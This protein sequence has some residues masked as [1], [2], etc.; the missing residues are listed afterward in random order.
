[1]QIHGQRCLVDDVEQCEKSIS[2][3]HGPF[4]R[5]VGGGVDCRDD[6]DGGEEWAV[7]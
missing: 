2:I 1:M 5:H 3:Y 6:R 7:V 4:L